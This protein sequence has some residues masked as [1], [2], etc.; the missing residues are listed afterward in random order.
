VLG[1]FMPR[2][3]KQHYRREDQRPE[4][5]EGKPSRRQQEKLFRPR[6]YGEP[7][8]P[9]MRKKRPTTVLATQC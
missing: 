7:D 2:Y 9:G 4:R 5:Q 6:A 8:E 1:G 3:E